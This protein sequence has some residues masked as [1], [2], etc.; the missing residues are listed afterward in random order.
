MSMQKSQ[1]P[2]FYRLM[3]G[4]CEVTA[5]FDSAIQF[6]TSIFKGFTDLGENEIKEMLDGDFVP[7]TAQGLYGGSLNAYLVNTGKHL[8]LVDA[9][10]GETK[11]PVFIDKKGRLMENLEA[12]GYRAEDVDI[13]LPTHLHFDHI[14]GVEA[15]GEMCFP[16]ATVYVEELERQFWLQSSSESIPENVLPFVEM[17]RKSLRPYEKSGRVKFYH[18]G[19]EIFPYIKSVPLY[20]HT[21]GHTGFM[22]ESENEKLILFG[23]FVHI[24]SVQLTRPEICDIFDMDIDAVRKA[25]FLG[26]AHFAEEKLMVAGAHFP[27]PGIGHIQKDSVGFRWFPIEY[28][29]HY[30]DM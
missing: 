30:I 6:D 9:G 19:E 11:S 2:G 7:H 27:F 17:A 16:N 8:I 24:K 10:I 25:R 20:G 12:A 4:E 21:P 15:N 5:L 26:L 13:V 14:A 18:A 23:D 22:V 3:I 1:V 28:T 29:H